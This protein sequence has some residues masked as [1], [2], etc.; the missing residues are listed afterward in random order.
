M[1]LRVETWLNLSDQPLNIALNGLLCAFVR[2]SPRRISELESW[3]NIRGSSL[4]VYTRDDGCAHL[5]HLV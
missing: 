4:H 3:R 2:S 1:N 5:D